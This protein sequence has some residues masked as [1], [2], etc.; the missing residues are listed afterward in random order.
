MREH[1]RKRTTQHRVCQPKSQTGGRREMY[2]LKITHANKDGSRT[3]LVTDGL[4]TLDN[5]H[6]FVSGY[7]D[8]LKVPPTTG[9]YI[10]VT[11]PPATIPVYA[12]GCG[13]ISSMRRAARNKTLCFT[14]KTEGA[15]LFPC[16]GI[17]LHVYGQKSIIVFLHSRG[18]TPSVPPDREWRRAAFSTGIACKKF[19]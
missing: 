3:N 17:N 18:H 16:R 11:G 1:R 9:V 2:K 14:L 10:V 6:E 8:S 4:T 5:V 7:L 19:H 12:N 13:P 15:W